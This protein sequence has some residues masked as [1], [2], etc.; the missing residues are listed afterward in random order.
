MVEKKGSDLILHS[1]V[2]L[3]YSIRSRVVK[4]VESRFTSVRVSGSNPVGSDR[5]A[6]SGL[7]RQT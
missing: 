5:V 6:Q 2:R 7:P 4:A 3:A 1:V